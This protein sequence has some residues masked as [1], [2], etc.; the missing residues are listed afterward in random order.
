[1][2]FQLF[3]NLTTCVF[4]VSEVCNKVIIKYF[5]KNSVS[6]LQFFNLFFPLRFIKVTNKYNGTLRVFSVYLVNHI[7]QFFKIIFLVFTIINSY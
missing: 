3:F 1:M 2:L 5:F 6:Y 7:N 4:N